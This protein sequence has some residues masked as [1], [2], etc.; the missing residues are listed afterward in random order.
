MT[1]LTLPAELCARIAAEARHAF[2]RECC[3]LIE[4]IREPARVQALA[5]HTAR[6]LAWSVDRFEIDPAIQFALTRKLRG[7]PRRIVGCYHSHPG[8]AA[9][10]SARDSA[11][12]SEED[13][14]WLIAA[15]SEAAI[16]PAIAAFQVVKGAFEPMAVES[17]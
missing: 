14:V 1:A 6:N 3:G 17:L 11:D 4:G 15:V 7:T 2:P 16:A 12:R 10:P 5:L 13:F 8:G 9:V